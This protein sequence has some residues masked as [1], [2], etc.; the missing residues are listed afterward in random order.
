[1]TLSPNS[2]RPPAGISVLQGL[3]SY[4][5]FIVSPSFALCNRFSANIPFHGTEGTA[6]GSFLLLA[7]LHDAPRHAGGMG[8]VPAVLVGG[9]IP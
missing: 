9:G 7:Q 6:G 4:C 3:F 1:M 8:R 5:A 2:K